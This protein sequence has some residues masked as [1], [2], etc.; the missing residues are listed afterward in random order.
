MTTVGFPSFVRN[1]ALPEPPTLRRGASLVV[2]VMLAAI[3]LSAVV[4]SSI[5]LYGI[6]YRLYVPQ[7]MHESAVHFQYPTDGGNTTALVTFV[8]ETD[9]KF[10][11]TSQA[12]TVSLDI[13]VPTSETNQQ[14]GSFMVYLELQ[15]RNGGVVKESARAAMVAYRSRMVR[16]LQT[17]VRAVPLALGLWRETDVVHVQL[18]DVLY[19]RHFSPITRA[20]VALSK[21]LQVYGARLVICAQFS[22]LRY[23]MYYWRLPTAIVFIGAAVAWQV[24]FTA[25]AWS[26][27]ESYTARGVGGGDEH[28]ALEESSSSSSRDNT[29]SGVGADRLRYASAKDVAARKRS[30]ARRRRRSQLRRAV[31]ESE[32]LGAL[33]DGSASIATMPEISHGDMDGE[34]RRVPERSPE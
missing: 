5:A 4:V 22:G 32:D 2:R 21:P 18:V 34:A 28:E 23:W 30:R 14:L 6:F 7:L 29:A 12:Y 11:S 33:D 25:G 27:L 26:V 31:S 3:A 19:D 20:K 24:L 9:Y 1:I 8:P 15:T 13:D 17:M 16:L 10:L